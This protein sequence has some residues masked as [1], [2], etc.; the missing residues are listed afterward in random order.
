[1]KWASITIILII[2]GFAYPTVMLGYYKE[3]NGYIAAVWLFC[4]ITSFTKWGH[5]DSLEIQNA[6][7]RNN[8]GKEQSTIRSSMQKDDGLL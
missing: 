8:Q 5:Y 6:F 2:L 7:V 4:F 3:V 1:M